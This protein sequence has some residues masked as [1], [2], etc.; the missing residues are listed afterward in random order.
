MHFLSSTTTN[1]SA[2]SPLWTILSPWGSK[3]IIMV[4]SSH[5]VCCTLVAWQLFAS[6]WLPLNWLTPLLVGNFMSWWYVEGIALN[7]FKVGLLI[8]ALHEMGWLATMNSTSCVAWA[9]DSTIDTCKWTEPTCIIGI[10]VKLISGIEM[11]FTWMEPT[12]N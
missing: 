4:S 5:R 7:K 1:S 10:V 9:G 2:G 11:R 6:F 12:S 8:I 3:I